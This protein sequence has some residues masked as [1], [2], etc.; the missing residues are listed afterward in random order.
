MKLW[1]KKKKITLQD[2]S[3]KTQAETMEEKSQSFKD[4][5][6]S[7]DEKLMVNNQTQIEVEEEK[8]TGADTSDE[9][10]VL[11]VLLEDI[12]PQQ[13]PQ[14]APDNSQTPVRGE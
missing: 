7:N 9:G 1:Y 13:A 4:T 8:V 10:S 6:T 11:E 14:H 5:Y 2:I 12:T 3:I